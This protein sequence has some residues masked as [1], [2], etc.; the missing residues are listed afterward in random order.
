MGRRMTLKGG[1]G[2]CWEGYVGI[3]SPLDSSTRAG[4]EHITDENDSDPHVV[5]GA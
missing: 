3:G 5:K 1:M 4:A 2:N